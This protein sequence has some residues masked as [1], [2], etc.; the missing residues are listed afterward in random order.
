ML[1]NPIYKVFTPLGASYKP[2][3]ARVKQGT[4]AGDNDSFTSSASQL[5]MRMVLS[6]R[7]P[8]RSRWPKP[9]TT[10][11]TEAVPLEGSVAP[12]TYLTLS[13]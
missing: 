8:F 6:G 7:Q 13:E 3:L 4:L 1:I 5:A 12:M 9:R 10:S 2:V 11:W